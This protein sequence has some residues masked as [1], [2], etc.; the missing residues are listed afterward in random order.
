MK[1]LLASLGF[2]ALAGMPAGSPATSV[3]DLSQ[4]R[5][6]EKQFETAFNNKDVDAMMAVY[7]PGDSL[8]V[9]DVVG[10]PGAELGSDAYRDAWT[11]FFAMFDGP[12]HYRIN[13]LEVTASGDLAYSRS[14]QHVSGTR[15]DGKPY[16]ITAR[17]TDVYR[18]IE[19]KW[20]IVQEHASL[21]IDRK[22]FTPILQS[23]L[24]PSK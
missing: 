17:V 7:A 4:L 14:L 24:P 19:G 11:H 1:K 22:T 8:F 9:F 6:L 2:L 20:L 23:S 16:D 5:M 18:K 13:D 15:K 12:V 10:P 21:A 3:D